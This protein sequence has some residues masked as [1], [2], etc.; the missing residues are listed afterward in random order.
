MLKKT[1]ITGTLTAGLLLLLFFVLTDP[2]DRKS[3]RESEYYAKTRAGIDS[4]KR[5]VKP[6]HGP[7]KAGFSKVSITP[8]I[9]GTADNPEKGE[10]PSLPLAGYGWR[11]GR[12]A[13]GVHDSLFVKAAAVEVEGQLLVIVGADLLLLPPY[14]TARVMDNLAEH[15]IQREQVF[16]TATHT[17]SSLGGWGRGLLGRQI[18][19][20]ENPGFVKWL[21][22]QV[23]S[24]VVMAVDDLQPASVA[25]GEFNAGMYTRNKLTGEPGTVNE[26][27]GYIYLVQDGGRK[28]VVGTYSAHATTLGRKHMEISADYPG[29]WQNRLEKEAVDVA[30][31][32]AGSVGN[33]QHNGKGKGY[34]SPRRLGEALADSTIARLSDSDLK[35]SITLSTATAPLFLP[36]FHLRITSGLALASPLSKY[37][38]PLQGES[39]LQTARIGDMVWV[40]TPGDLS[41]DYARALKDALSPRDLNLNATSFNGSYIGYIL[42]VNYYDLDKPESRNMVFYGPGTG[43]YIMDLVRQM[44]DV[45]IGKEVPETPQP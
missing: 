28:A 33:Q 10:F 7:V 31:F 4:L 41:G 9:N 39:H 32:C 1:L 45:I 6:V 11:K 19:G 8:A 3:Y 5:T 27:L 12:P 36:D 24:A 38:L 40:T 23:S 30:I 16:F 20:K 18:A 29:Y 14:I 35:D 2:I 43:D 25:I 17:H 13:E 15:N 22:G 26:D 44:I 37:L 34:E 42:P 21:A